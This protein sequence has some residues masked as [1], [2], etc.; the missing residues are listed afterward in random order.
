[1]QKKPKNKKQYKQQN[2]TQTQTLYPYKNF[3][4]TYQSKMV[5]IMTWTTERKT[6][7]LLE[8]NIGKNLDDLGYMLFEKCCQDNEKTS[9]DLEQ[10]IC[11]KYTYLINNS[12]KIHKKI[13]KTQP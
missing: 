5:P 10:N 11:K 12:S 9:H 13:T 6:I 8:D 4:V 1:M 2:R 3:G 7:N